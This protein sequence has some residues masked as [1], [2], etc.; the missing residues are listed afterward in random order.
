VWSRSNT[1]H[2]LQSLGV[3]KQAL[4]KD[5]HGPAGETKERQSTTHYIIEDKA[6]RL[7]RQST[8]S[9]QDQKLREGGH[10]PY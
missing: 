10:K 6:I 7:S 4:K 8:Q 3:K 1:L 5:R 9:E 2:D